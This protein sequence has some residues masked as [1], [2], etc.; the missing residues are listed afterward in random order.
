MLTC[1]SVGV[2]MSWSM[3]GS[4]KTSLDVCLHVLP[5]LRQ[6]LLFATVFAKLVDCQ[7]LWILSFFSG[8]AYMFSFAIFSFLFSLFS[9]LYVNIY[10]RQSC[11]TQTVSI[12]SEKSVQGLLPRSPWDH[13]FKIYWAKSL[14]A[15]YG[16]LM[17]PVFGNLSF[18]TKRQKAC[19]EIQFPGW[20]SPK[21]PW[22][23]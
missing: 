5:W 20:I 11:G 4:Q 21:T 7:L 1:V 13:F 10:P 17:S 6:C 19:F 14:A 12:H 3:H 8:L 23:L 22:L 18:Q 15:S 9:V 2:N 16:F